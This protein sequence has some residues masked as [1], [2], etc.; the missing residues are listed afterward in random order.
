MWLYLF[1]ICFMLFTG[2]I[3]DY[4]VHSRLK[5]KFYIIL[6]FFLFTILSGFRSENV[7]NDTSAYI[8][9]FNNISSSGDISR[10]TWRFELGYLYLNKLLSLVSSNSQTIIIGTSIIIMAGFARFIYL[11][12][13]Q[14]WLSIYLFFTIGYFAMS[15]NTI[16]LNIAMVILLFSYDFLKNRKLI[17]FVL[18]VL[19]ASLFHRTAIVFLLAWPITKL[20]YNYRTILVATISSI[21]LYLGF[22][23]ILPFFF[24]IFPTYQYYLGSELLDGNIRTASIMNLLVGLAIVLLGSFVHFNNIRKDTTLKAIGTEQEKDNNDESMLLLLITGVSI[25]FISFNFNILDR[26]GEYFAVF[27]I[28][29][30]PNTL[31]R[32]RDRNLRVLIYYIVVILFF[33]YSITII[34]M[35]PEWNTIYP[36]SFFWK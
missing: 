15:M 30:L 29:Y 24:N 9:V 26:V 23:R 27:S 19:L 31:N 13:E 6:N 4:S 21:G 1:L 2:L 25:T 7:G 22:P 5:T 18:V 35:R 33:A 8:G 16:R 17:K 14:K 34:I 3:F 28:V 11:Y 12:S 20:S 32:L 10:Y 36:Y